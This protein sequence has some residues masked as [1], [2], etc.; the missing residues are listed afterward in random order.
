MY[1]LPIRP[2]VLQERA[3]LSPVPRADASQPASHPALR[4]SHV[5]ASCTH[6]LGKPQ[7]PRAKQQI[8]CY[9]TTACCNRNCFPDQNALHIVGVVM[10]GSPAFCLRFLFTLG[11]PRFLRARPPQ[12]GNCGRVQHAHHNIA[13]IVEPVCNGGRQV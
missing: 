10:R 12:C 7:P 3:K 2:E 11:S 1:R 4:H 8:Y 9:Q 13:V 5:G 6:C